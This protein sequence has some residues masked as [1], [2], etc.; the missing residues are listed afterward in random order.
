M[1]EYPDETFEYPVYKNYSLDFARE[2]Q[3]KIENS[4]YNSLNLYINVTKNIRSPL[5]R[6]LLAN[7]LL[8]KI[9]NEQTKSSLSVSFHSFQNKDFSV[10]PDL[11]LKKH[12]TIKPQIYPC[13]DVEVKAKKFKICQEGFL[14]LLLIH[15]EAVNDFF[16]ISSAIKVIQETNDEDKPIVKQEALENP[17]Q[18]TFDKAI[19]KNSR[20][21]LSNEVIL[22]KIDL[23]FKKMFHIRLTKET[24]IFYR[25]EMKTLLL[26]TKVIKRYHEK[27]GSK[28]D[29]WMSF[30]NKIEVEN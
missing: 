26:L 22:R 5:T 21:Q 16:Q 19:F 30:I 12:R 25:E 28:Y 10:F 7:F 9:T 29:I 8:S 15:A 3:R 14:Q 17:V 1:Y 18:M 23:N 11:P 2:I 4:N 13:C 24:C 20:K 6:M 27:Y